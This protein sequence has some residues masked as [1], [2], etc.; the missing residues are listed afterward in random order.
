MVAIRAGILSFPPV[1]SLLLGDYSLFPCPGIAV[2]L[3][4]GDDLHGFAG[5]AKIHGV[6]KSV[7]QSSLNVVFNFRK[8]KWRLDN[9]LEDRIELAQEFITQPDSS[10]LIPRRRIA[11]IKFSLGEDS[12]ASRHGVEWCARSLARSSS[13]KSSQDLPP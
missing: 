4:N 8:L 9:P 5:H 6:G 11:D 3:E 13:R 12:E 10:H 1:S 7:K 2:L